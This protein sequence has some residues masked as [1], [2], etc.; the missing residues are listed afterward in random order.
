MI[1]LP[2]PRARC[3]AYS[4]N[5][6]LRGSEWHCTEGFHMRLLGHEP[7]RIRRGAPERERLAFPNVKRRSGEEPQPSEGDRD[8]DRDRAARPR[9][10]CH[11]HNERNKQRAHAGN[12]RRRGSARVFQSFGLQHIPSGE[13]RPRLQTCAASRF[14]G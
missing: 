2:Q 6:H 3:G 7:E 12:E 5:K 11:S 10:P 8:S 9:A 4:H 13:P 14:H 1:R